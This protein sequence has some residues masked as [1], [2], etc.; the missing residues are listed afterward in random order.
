MLLE[1]VGNGEVAESIV[2]VQIP[3]GLSLSTKMPARAEDAPGHGQAGSGKG[4][5]RPG[6]RVRHKVWGMGTIIKAEDKGND[7]EITIAFP[8]LGVKKVLASVAPLK[9]LN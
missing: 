5:Y 6:S 4:H 7:T 8:G 9:A 3:A 1:F 2:P